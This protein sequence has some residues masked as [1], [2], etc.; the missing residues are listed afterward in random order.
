MPAQLNLVERKQETNM[1]KI[2][3]NTKA[4][5]EFLKVQDIFLPQQKCPVRESYK[6]Q[7]ICLSVLKQKTGIL[8]CLTG[9]FIAL[10]YMVFCPTCAI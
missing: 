3:L 2:Q 1:V 8:K 9:T 4:A 6:M 5:D 10:K 7:P